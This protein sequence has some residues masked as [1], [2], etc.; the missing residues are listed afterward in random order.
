MMTGCGFKCE[1]YE[2]VAGYREGHGEEDREKCEEHHFFLSKYVTV[3]YSLGFSNHN[4]PSLPP[5]G[6]PFTREGLGFIKQQSRFSA[7]LQHPS[8]G[9]GSKQ[10]GARLERRLQPHFDVNEESPGWAGQA[11]GLVGHRKKPLCR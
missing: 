6:H 11:E 2:A 9:P 4:L 8:T 1:L 7:Q 10:S 5:S 3:L